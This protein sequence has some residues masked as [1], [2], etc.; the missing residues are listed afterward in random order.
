VISGELEEK[1]K[2]TLDT[3]KGIFTPPQLA[4]V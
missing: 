4:L 3:F 1:M 2:R